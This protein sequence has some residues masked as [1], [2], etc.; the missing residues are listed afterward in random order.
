MVVAHKFVPY[1]AILKS[2]YSVMKI[3]LLVGRS[4]HSVV[5]VQAEAVEMVAHIQQY[6]LV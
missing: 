1:F 2:N 6:I 5:V 4:V 3:E